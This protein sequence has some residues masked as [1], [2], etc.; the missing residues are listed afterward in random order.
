MQRKSSSLSVWKWGSHFILL[1]AILLGS[2]SLSFAQQE[3]GT[4]KGIVR[5]VSGA[6]IQNAAITCTNVATGVVSKTVSDT[7][8]YFTIPYLSPGDYDVTAASQGFARSIVTGIHLTVNLTA[9]IQL[10]LKPGSVTQQVSV[11]ANAI[12][13]ET[14]TSELGGTVGREQIIELPQ[15]GRN[16]Y[17][18]LALEPGVLPVYFNAGIQAEV[19]GGEANTSNILLDGAT[20][21]NSSSGDPAFTPPL[22]SVG[23]MKLIT[24]NYSAEYGMSGGG[25]ERV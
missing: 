9:S 19:N 14:E 7:D 6:I 13:L 1:W 11:Q 24:N 15:L 12:Q 10:T 16:P 22:E 8:G 21:V 18:L 2:G 20:Q 23:Q 5:D 3:Q 4:I 17:N 25:V